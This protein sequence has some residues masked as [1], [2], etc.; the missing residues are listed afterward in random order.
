MPTQVQA[1]HN[2]LEIILFKEGIDIN[3]FSMILGFLHLQ[4]DCEH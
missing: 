2:P 1:Y 3:H 4:F